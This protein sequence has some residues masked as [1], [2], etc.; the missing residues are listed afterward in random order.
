MISCEKGNEADPPP[1]IRRRQPPRLVPVPA[2]AGPPAA[3]PFQQLQDQHRRLGDEPGPSR[4]PGMV[5]L[6]RGY[7]KRQTWNYF[8][9][10]FVL[11][12]IKRP[13][14]Y[15]AVRHGVLRTV[16]EPEKAAS[17][18]LYVHCPRNRHAYQLRYAD[19]GHANGE[20]HEQP[21]WHC[22]ALHSHPDSFQYFPDSQLCQQNPGGHR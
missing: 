2:P 9:E 22:P 18:S 20:S 3:D 19:D 10:Q 16:P 14:V 8:F 17:F 13:A 6:F 12:S 7:R 4:K 11:F 21:D 15:A 5:Q 1:E